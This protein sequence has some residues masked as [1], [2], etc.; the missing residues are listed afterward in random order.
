MTRSLTIVVLS[1]A[2]AT[3]PAIAQ[4]GWWAWKHTTLGYIA[5]IPPDFEP[6]GP[7]AGDN[8]MAFSVSPG[9]AQLTVFAGPLGPEGVRAELAIH[10]QRLVAAGGSMNLEFAG[11]NEAWLMGTVP[12]GGV[13]TRIRAECGGASHLTIILSWQEA[14]RATFAPLAVEIATRMEQVFCSPPGQRP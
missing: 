14:E 12:S 2:V 7:T 11:D 4:E 10:R 9:R 5:W 3:A 6:L 13:H 1:L 8:G